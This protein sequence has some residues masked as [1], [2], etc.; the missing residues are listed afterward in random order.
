VS[1]EAFLSTSNVVKLLGGRGSAPDAAGETYS[2]PPDPALAGEEGVACPFP[3]TLLPLSALRASHLVAFGHS[4]H[5][6]S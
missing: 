1:A 6:P 3:R 2:A 4:F 5:A